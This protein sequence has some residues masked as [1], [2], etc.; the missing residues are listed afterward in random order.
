MGGVRLQPRKAGSPSP[1]KLLEAER[2][3]PQSFPREPGPA[4]ARFKTLGPR[5]VNESIPVLCSHQVSGHLSQET[6]AES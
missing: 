5:T 3:A 4:G 2:A 6:N 1:Q